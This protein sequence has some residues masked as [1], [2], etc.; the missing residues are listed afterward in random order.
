MQDL[1]VEGRK[2]LRVSP[3]F[4]G[5]GQTLVVSVTGTSSSTF[6]AISLGFTILGEI[7][8]YVTFFL[9]QS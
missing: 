1:I 2:A 7:L 6:S 9:L 4:S 5:E 3:Y 8:V